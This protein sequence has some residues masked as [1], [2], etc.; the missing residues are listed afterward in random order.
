LLNP[1]RLACFFASF[2]FQL[3][4][5]FKANRFLISHRGMAQQCDRASGT[6]N[7]H[8]IGHLRFQF[9][10]LRAYFPRS[11][12]LM[13]TYRV[14]HLACDLIGFPCAFQLAV[15]GHFPGNFLELALRLFERAFDPILINHG[16]SPL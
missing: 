9:W 4:L 6:T 7:R 12:S 5:A 14:P 11:V 3:P 2:V 16:L 1:L 8:Q 15:S 10:L 13:P